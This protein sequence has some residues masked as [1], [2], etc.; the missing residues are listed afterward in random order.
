M[1][2]DVLKDEINAKKLRNVYLFYGLEEYLKRYYLDLIEP[3]IVSH[4]F[5]E[6]NKFVLED[7][8]DIEKLT[9]ICDTYPV[10]SDRKLIIIKNSEIFKP[11]KKGIDETKN[12]SSYHDNIIELL[13]SLPQYD[14]IIFYENEI[15]KRSKVVNQ[16]KKDG[17]IVEFTY[18][19]P[20]AKIVWITNYFESLNKKIDYAV[21][22]MLIDFCNEGMASI[23]IEAKKLESFVGTREVIVR[24]DIEAIC[25]KSIKSRIF[26]LSDAISQKDANKAMII[27][28]DMILL[29]E[30]IPK[31]LFMIAKQFRQMLDIKTSSLEG[32]SINDIATK[33]GLTPFIIRKIVIYTTRSVLM[34]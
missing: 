25:S 13:K 23:L 14:Y 32:E 27:L 7:K 9:G 4:E 3:L 29:K 20:Q 16:I 31:I 2:I 30:P 11:S 1:S 5:K 12:S 28:N 22:S 33:I 26:D 19:K 8:V 21:A 17:L 18:Q 10:F 34:N 24:E 6:L 15:D